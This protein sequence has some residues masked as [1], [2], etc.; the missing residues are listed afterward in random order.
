MA[1]FAEDQTIRCLHCRALFVWSLADQAMYASQGF[2][3][4]HFCPRCRRGARYRA[5]RRRAA[6]RD[7]A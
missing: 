1:V 3:A 6:I 2:R 5:A 4:P 7:Q